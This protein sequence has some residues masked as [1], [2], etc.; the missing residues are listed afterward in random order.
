MAAGP[1]K[2]HRRK[3]FN[4][5]RLQP[6]SG[7]RIC[8]NAACSAVLSV[9]DPFCRR[10]S[11]CICEK[12]D[13][14]KD[15]TLWL[16]CS[17]N[18]PI[19]SCGLSCHIKCALETKKVGVANI[20]Q[21]MRLD[22]AYWCFH[23][24]HISGILGCLKRL[25]T[26]PKD[27]LCVSTLCERIELSFKLLN[28]TTKFQDLLGTVEEAKIKLEGELGPPDGLCSQMEPRHVSHTVGAEVLELCTAAVK[29]VDELTASL[30]GEGPDL[31][32][33]QMVVYDPSITDGLQSMPNGP[34]LNMVTV[35]EPSVDVP[36]VNDSS[37]DNTLSCG[38]SL[39]GLDLNMAIDP[40]PNLGVND[41]DFAF[42]G[43]ENRADEEMQ[44]LSFQAPAGTE[45]HGDL[46]EDFESCLEVIERL[47]RNNHITS[48]VRQKLFTWFSLRASKRQRR[49]VRAFITAF[50]DDSRALVAQLADTFGA[51]I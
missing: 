30:E 29:K 40:E 9:F 16:E 36:P 4:P 49:A 5:Q 12:H 26:L 39:F 51:A 20:C 23:C 45:A 34:D 8:P 6:C 47:E 50:G 46:E 1:S 11:C 2:L 48:E 33:L 44:A 43:S 17:P 42:G 38:G 28:G 37:R 41:T 18:S 24:G 21:M 35:P 31:N 19:R 27:P 7:E 3:R 32:M 22:G 10:C 14:E 13:T 25:L 15:P